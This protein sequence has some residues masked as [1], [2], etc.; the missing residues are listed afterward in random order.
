MNRTIWIVIGV[1][2]LLGLGGLVAFT[3][4]GE[5]NVDN[6]DAATIIQSS[7]G[8]IG[9]R[10]TGKS[11]AKVIVF[12]YADYQCPGCGAAF[13]TT[14]TI[15]D[16]YKDKVA[17][18]FRNFPLTSIHP[19]ALAAASVAEAAGQQGKFW[20]MHDLLFTQRS[21]WVNLSA[22]QRGSV[23]VGYAQQLG[24]DTAKFTSDQSSKLVSEKIN[25]DRA[26]GS[27]VGVN[28]TP[29]FFIGSTKIDATT[30]DEVINGK[31]DSFMSKLDDALRAAGETPP[32]R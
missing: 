3:K 11:D 15:Q 22:D 18:V 7:N 9:D 16:T 24:L 31:A 5:T 2:C 23:F 32:V 27:K 17:F 30:T 19:N 6:V 12:E 10:T 13:S 25:F 29:S 4:Q 28:S 21:A 26:L 20:E 1:V 14:K 8:S